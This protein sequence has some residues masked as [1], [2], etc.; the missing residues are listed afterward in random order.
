LNK[1]LK[2]R[3]YQTKFFHLPKLAGS[4]YHSAKRNFGAATADWHQFLSV[5]FQAFSAI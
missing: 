2:Q 4:L 5:W 3:P 1:K